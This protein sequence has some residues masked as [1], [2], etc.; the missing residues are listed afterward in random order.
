MT[1]QSGSLVG[2][3]APASGRWPAGVE[4]WADDQIVAAV[5]A[6]SFSEQ[7]QSEGWRHGWCGFTIEGA[8]E[9]FAV[10]SRC[11]L[12]CTASGAVLATLAVEQLLGPVAVAPRLSLEE[13]LA[14][15][16]T[17]DCAATV[18]QILPFALSFSRRVGI[19][20]FVEKSCTMLLHRFVDYGS[21]KLLAGLTG[22]EDPH[23]ILELIAE[24]TEIE[25][26]ALAYIPGPFHP[27]FLYG[28]DAFG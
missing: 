11:S 19:G 8:G 14:H 2:Y 28:Y 23:T 20:E 5:A 22:E 7:A 6:T 25:E 4:L 24:T 16:R 21:A 13:M 17:A 1:V 10:A 26:S 15:V 9:G 27:E 12:R 3:A 18:E